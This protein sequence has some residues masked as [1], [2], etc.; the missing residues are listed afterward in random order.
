MEME[1]VY[2]GVKKVN[3]IY[4]GYTV[5]TD[6]PKEKGGEGTA[7][8]PFDLFLSS[9]GTCAGFYVFSFCKERE[10]PTD[11]IKLTLQT[12]KNKETGMIGKISI[13]IQLPSGF[14]EK[15]KKAVIRSADQCAVKKHI[16]NPP[17]FTIHTKTI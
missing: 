10:I 8:A 2:D 13:E 4:N 6:Q 17:E 7:P 14:P 11:G 5:R 16:F 9:I 15:Y 3:A 12:E 1:V